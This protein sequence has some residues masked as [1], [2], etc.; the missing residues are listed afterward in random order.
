MWNGNGESSAEVWSVPDRY[1]FNTWSLLRPT[2]L[3]DTQNK[4]YVL[5]FGGSD[6]LSMKA[7]YFSTTESAG[8]GG[9]FHQLNYSQGF[10]YAIGSWSGTA[11]SSLP[12]KV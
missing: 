11:D 1:N 8:V 12:A 4:G 10:V 5:K 9:V 6:F 3:P 7:S 2:G